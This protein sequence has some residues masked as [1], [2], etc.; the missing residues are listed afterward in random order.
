MIEIKVTCSGEE[1]R[2]HNFEGARIRIGRHEDNDLVLTSKACSRHHAEIIQEGETYKIVDLG[3]SNK[4]RLGSKTLTELILSDGCTVEIGEYKLKFS[5]GEE[6]GDETVM[7]A[8]P[9]DGED[10]TVVDVVEAN[11]QGEP[12]V[13]YLHYQRK[14]QAQSLKV[15]HG[16]EYVIGR[17][18]DADVVIDD[19]QSSAHHSTVFS[20]AGQFYI[21]DNNSSNGTSVNGKKIDE[22]SL[23]A[24]SQIQIGNTVITMRQER[25]KLADEA[26]LL[27]RTILGVPPGALDSIS[28]KQGQQAGTD[29]KKGSGLA[30]AIAA[31]AA[32][33]IAVGAFVILGGGGGEQDEA[34]ENPTGTDTASSEVPSEGLIVQ[35]AVIEAKEITS[36]VSGTGTVNPGRR[37]TVSAEVPGRILTLP[38]DE[39]TFV[40]RGQLLATI[41]DR[42][43]RLQI[44][45]ARSAVSLDRVELAR[46][47]SERKQRL[48]DDGVTTRSVLDQSKNNYLALDS[49]YKSAQAKIRQLEEQLGKTRIVAPISGRVA[50][51]FLN[52]GEFLAPGTPLITLENMDE[53]LVELELSDRDIVKIKKGQIVEASLD[54][55]PGKTFQGVVDNIASAAHPVTRTFKVEARIGNQDGSLRSGMI[56]SLRIILERSHGLVVPTEALMDRRDDEA[57]VFVV[58]EGTARKVTIRLGGTFDREVEV[59]EGL[60][61]GDLVVVYGKEQVS[62]GQPID[63]YQRQ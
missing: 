61:E 21:R 42:D 48:F 35:V 59:V 8:K 27:E 10:K 2:V 53:I 9:T 26:A 25:H 37:V 5:L 3:S 34:I 24:G 7:I 38:V 20:K 6:P 29:S 31:A 36:A 40:R 41:N 4:I 17:A 28:T 44:D 1:P 52:Q 57:D 39:G 23:E 54:A 46:E 55:F 51:K 43:I 15:V 62:D 30:V 11:Q 13:L 60:T 32:V 14:N 12:P 50:R 33:A 45:E 16:A 18:P 22:T 19:N 63:S 56:T 47:D 49:A 58:A